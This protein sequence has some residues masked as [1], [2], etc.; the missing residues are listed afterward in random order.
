MQKN[1]SKPTNFGAQIANGRLQS[2]F[3]TGY[4]S[5]LSLRAKEQLFSENPKSK[6]LSNFAG[7]RL[8]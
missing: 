1:C 3:E 5:L 8:F 4:F 7:L 6:K 2:A